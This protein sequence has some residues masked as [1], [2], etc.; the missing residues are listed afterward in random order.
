VSLVVWLGVGGVFSAIFAFTNAIALA[1]SLFVVVPPTLLFSFECVATWFLCRALPL[2]SNSLARAL[3]SHSLIAII[4]GI[5]WV[6]IASGW[7][8]L[9]FSAELLAPIQL[10]VLHIP[11]WVGA[12][13]GLYLLS[14]AFFYVLI[15]MEDS[16]R[17]EQLAV[18][19][20]MLAQEAELRFLRTQIDPHFLFNSLN[21]I[22]ALTTNSPSA[23]REMTI[24]LGEFLRTSLQLGGEKEI[25][26][27]QELELVRQ[28]LRIEQVR[29]D[30]RL[31]TKFEIDP[32]TLLCKLPP[33]IIQPLVE[34]AVKHG[35]ASLVEGGSIN[36][37][38]AK[39]G[40]FISVRVENP[41]DAGSKSPR[42]SGMG[43]SNVRQRLQASYGN[44]AQLLTTKR[45]ETFI[46]EVTLP[47]RV[48]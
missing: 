25:T 29:F 32:P 16:Q 19:S 21:S 45:E 27:E 38:V 34:N 30:T 40:P 10:N 24:L 28:F 4:S 48:L 13:A 46:A 36:I 3:A 15:S 44:R 17:A 37:T 7:I 8:K 33:L 35:V 9:L 47:L 1:P 31:R 2:R 26:V 18:E 5:V 39:N 11:W 23:A 42:Q 6:G 12:V 41:F 14:A 43:I 22:S 20:R